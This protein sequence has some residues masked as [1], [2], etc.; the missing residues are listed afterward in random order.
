M[1]HLTVMILVRDPADVPRVRDLL[2]E[3]SLTAAIYRIRF[4]LDRYFAEL[5]ARAF[6]PYAEVVF[7]VE[8]P[9]THYH[10][11]LLLSPFGYSTYRGS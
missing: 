9:S 10:I 7:R 2:A 6:Y 5:G 3:G 4:E 11:P 8:E 1:I